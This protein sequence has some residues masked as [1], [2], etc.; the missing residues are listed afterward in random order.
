WGTTAGGVGIAG[1][2]AGEAGSVAGLTTRGVDAAVVLAVA[3]ASAPAMTITPA[4]DGIRYL[5]RRASI[6][7][8]SRWRPRDAKTWGILS[9]PHRRGGPVVAVA[10]MRSGPAPPP[11]PDL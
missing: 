9:I 5:L 6:G 4:A 3:A 11:A 10:T 7:P 2:T 8:P 1:W